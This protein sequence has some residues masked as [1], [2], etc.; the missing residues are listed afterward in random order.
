[1]KTTL[2]K[3]IKAYSVGLAVLAITIQPYYFGKYIGINF[4]VGFLPA[5]I[6]SCIIEAIIIISL[7]AP[8]FIGSMILGSIK[9]SKNEKK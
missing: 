6:W 7:L 1:M 9:E 4:Q 3:I 8:F 2:S 5:Y